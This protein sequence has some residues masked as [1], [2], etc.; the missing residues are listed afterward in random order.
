M[1]EI[2]Q[3]DIKRAVRERYGDIAAG[4]QSCCGPQGD[5][6]L[7]LVPTSMAAVSTPLGCGN[8]TA[9]A[10]LRPGETVLD[11]GSGPG[12]DC[13]LAASKVGPAGWVIG[14]DMT[15][16]MLELARE[17]A[18]RGGVSNVEYRLG[19][20]EALPVEDSS[21]DV[22]ISNC[23]IN[24][25]PDKDAVFREAYRVLKPGGRLAVAD[26]VALQPLDEAQRNDLSSWSACVSGSL[27]RDDYRRRLEAAGFTAIEFK[28]V[29]G[30]AACA[31]SA[32]VVSMEIAA[33]KR[34][35]VGNVPAVAVTLC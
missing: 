9:I 10:A 21:V 14:V 30:A 17:G 12:L 16:A 32:P 1:E 13:L 15:P 6:T 20:I 4:G 2:K 29:G 34:T 25:A 28:E 23:V 27:E 22:I 7:V 8:P 31:G 11:L 19:D 35:Q 33:V 18:R 24:L 3:S 26:T 5:V